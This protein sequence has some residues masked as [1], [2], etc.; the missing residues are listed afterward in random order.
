MESTAG[1][2]DSDDTG[3]DGD[4][5]ASATKRNSHTQLDQYGNTTIGRLNEDSRDLELLFL[6]DLLHGLK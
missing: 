1:S 5:N 6:V 3:L 4:G 2:S